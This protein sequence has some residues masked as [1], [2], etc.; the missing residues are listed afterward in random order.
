MPRHGDWI[1]RRTV[2]A[3]SEDRKTE[4]GQRDANLVEK[5]GLG[6][7]L[8][9]R[10]AAK[11]FECAP[12]Q[13]TDM[14]T[15]RPFEF[16]F[17]DHAHPR[18]PVTGRDQADLE[19]ALSFERT[20]HK[21]AIRLLNE[22][23]PEGSAQALPGVFFCRKEQ[24]TRRIDVEPVDDSTS[25][26]SFAHAVDFGKSS[27]QRIQHGVGLILSER[28]DGSSGGLVDR[29]PTA[30]PREHRE[31]LIR[32]GQRPLIF[33]PRKG[34]YL[35][36]GPRLKIQALGVLIYTAP[37]DAHGAAR[38]QPTHLRAREPQTLGEKPVEA[39]AAIFFPDRQ[40]LAG[41]GHEA[42]LDCPGLRQQS[43]AG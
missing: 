39:L 8:D 10:H 19:T 7:N 12:T 13:H 11:D 28:V 6:P 14:S 3:V 30:S 27:D 21:R 41:L 25:Q 37:T 1:A 34:G 20:D 23:L 5:A 40:G 35:D 42:R 38:E 26:A 31:R 43:L 36:R 16:R 22:M 29:E 4:V 32:A 17:G 18:G 33:G 2:A 24:H 9:E 15:A